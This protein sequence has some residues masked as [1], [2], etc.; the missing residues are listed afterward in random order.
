[1]LGMLKMIPLYLGS[2][3]FMCKIKKIPHNAR[4]PLFLV[5]PIYVSTRKRRPHQEYGVVQ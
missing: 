2:V 1:M 3:S 5:M 4:V